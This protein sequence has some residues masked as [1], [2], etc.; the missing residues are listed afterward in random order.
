[1]VK[2]WTT[3]RLQLGEQDALEAGRQVGLPPILVSEFI[4]YWVNSGDLEESWIPVARNIQSPLGDDPFGGGENTNDTNLETRPLVF[5]CHAS[6]DKSLV[7][8]Y[9]S[10]FCAAGFDAWLDEDQIL[11]GQDWDLEIRRALKRS[12]SVVIFLSRNSGKQG[13]LQKEIL[14]ALDEAEQQPEGTIFLIPAKLEP[15]QVPDRLSRVQWVDLQADDGFQR[16]CR[17]LET[18]RLSGS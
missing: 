5:L 13:Y 1:L 18:H 3:P 17:A 6:E 4:H 14:R 16:L 15:C 9:K 7:R 8:S 11:P 10:R 2:R 12:N